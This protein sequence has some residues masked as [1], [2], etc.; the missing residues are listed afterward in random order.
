MWNAHSNY[1]NGLYK[2]H[3][4]YEKTNLM[5]QNFLPRSHILAMLCVVP[6]NLFTLFLPPFGFICG[7][8]SVAIALYWDKGAFMSLKQSC[9]LGM[10]TGA[11]GGCFAGI[12][13]YGFYWFLS[14]FIDGNFGSMERASLANYMHLQISNTNY[15][16]IGNLCLT[17]ISNTLGGWFCLRFLHSYRI[18]PK[19]INE[20]WMQ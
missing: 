9:F 16:F 4:S 6:L 3:D 19:E 17:M 7:G 10:L 1:Q 8:M 18:L 2:E 14:Y 20:R 13:G 12:C 5:K 15:I 11:L